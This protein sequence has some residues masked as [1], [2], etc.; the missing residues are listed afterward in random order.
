LYT[1]A[2]NAS[3]QWAIWPAADRAELLGALTEVTAAI[4]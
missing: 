2:L 3:R 1:V 4:D